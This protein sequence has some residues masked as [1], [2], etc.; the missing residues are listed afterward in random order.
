MKDLVKII[1]L[2]TFFQ[3]NFA[4]E[5]PTNLVQGDIT[6]V[7]TPAYRDTERI[8]LRLNNRHTFVFKVKACSEAHVYFLEY[9]VS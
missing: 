2:L 3:L 4:A 1:Y 9:F 7:W 5:T 8:R 6:T